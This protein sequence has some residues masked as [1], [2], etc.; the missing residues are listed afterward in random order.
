LPVKPDELVLGRFL[1]RAFSP[2]RIQA[3]KNFGFAQ[4]SFNAFQF[5]QELERLTY[6]GAG[7][8]FQV[9]DDSVTTNFRSFCFARLVSG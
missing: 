9:S 4:V 2:P 3:G 5:E 6:D 7:F 8:Y 1:I